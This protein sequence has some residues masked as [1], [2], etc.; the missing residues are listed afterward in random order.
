MNQQKGQTDIG[1]II[2]AIIG[3]IAVIVAAV[4]TIRGNREQ[5]SSQATQQAL[6]ATIVALPKP[7]LVPT[8]QPNTAQE[9]VVATSVPPT[10]VPPTPALPAPVPPAPTSAPVTPVSIQ[11]NCSSNDWGSC[12]S[13]DDNAQTMTW[14]GTSD[15]KIGQRGIALDKTQAGYIVIFTNSIAMKMNICVGIVDSEEI[16]KDCTPQIRTILPGTHRV[17]SPGWQG[18]FET[19]P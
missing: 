16:A 6:Q 9:Q 14:I 19:F 18:G 15:A 10:P 2:A 13:Y 11:A 1:T 4:I 3:A 12:W 7:T 17:V 5:Q 8:Q